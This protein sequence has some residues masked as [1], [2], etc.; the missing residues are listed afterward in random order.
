MDNSIDSVQS[1]KS[2]KFN[3]FQFKKEE[4]PLPKEGIFALNSKNRERGKDPSL[5]SK[6]SLRELDTS[7]LSEN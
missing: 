2:G 1:S 5:A 6:Q 4:R 3:R 7:K